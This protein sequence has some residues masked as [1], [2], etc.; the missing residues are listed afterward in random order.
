MTPDEEAQL[1]SDIADLRRLGTK[2]ALNAADRVEARLIMIK[3]QSERFDQLTVERLQEWVEEINRSRSIKDKPIEEWPAYL[4]DE[5]FQALQLAWA[6]SNFRARETAKLLGLDLK[7]VAAWTSGECFQKW[8]VDAGPRSMR[9]IAV[10]DLAL[11]RIAQVLSI[12]TN[13]PAMLDRQL[14]AAGQVMTAGIT[15]PSRAPQGPKEPERKR[16]LPAG[17]GERVPTRTTRTRAVK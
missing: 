1:R 16:A 12:E 10:A 13:D 14:K 9:V 11:A 15:L 5:M 2:E 8:S 3:R 7:T 6:A 17:D 4:R